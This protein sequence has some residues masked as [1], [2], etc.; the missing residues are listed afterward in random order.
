MKA[1]LAP[2]IFINASRDRRKRHSMLGR[3]LEGDEK[4]LPSTRHIS[5][6]TEFDLA[7]NYLGEKKTGG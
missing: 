1:G 2:V 3:I 5:S 4:I 6:W 7:V